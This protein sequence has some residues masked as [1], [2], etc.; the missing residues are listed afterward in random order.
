MIHQSLHQRERETYL[1][2]AMVLVASR[3]VGNGSLRHKPKMTKRV[4]VLGFSKEQIFDY[5]NKYHF[6]SDL[7]RSDAL[8]W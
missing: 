1:A 7:S 8:N 3:P 2:E 6:S 5:I 4:E